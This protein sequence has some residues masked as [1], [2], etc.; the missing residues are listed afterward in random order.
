MWGL[1]RK[2]IR[3]LDR[4]RVRTLLT[5]LGIAVGV[6]GIVAIMST[7]RN[8]AEAQRSLFVENAQAHI[9]YWVWDAPASLV[10]L[11]ESDRRIVA[12][13][14]RLT[15]VTKWRTQGSW[16]DI[17]LVGIND[18]DRVRV[19]LWELLEGRLPRLD[20]VVLEASDA[21]AFG[22]AMG[23]RLTYRDFDGRER[24]ATISGTS[25]SPS[26]LSSTIT[27]LTVAYVPAPVLRRILGIS[28]S[29]QLLIRLAD[30]ADA[31]DVA[32]RVGRLLD[33]ASIQHGSAR[34]RDPDEFPGK[35][36]LDALIVIMYLFTAL[37]LVVSALL[38]TN[39]LSA[40]IAEQVRDIAI[41]KAIGATHGH[42]LLVYLVQAVLYG[43]GGTLLGL[44][45][46]SVLGWRIL[47]WIGAL[48]HVEV[49]F[50]VAAGALA[51]GALLGMGVTLLSAMVPVR[52]GSKITIH[53]ALESYG[54]A[55]TYGQ[56]RLDRAL[57]RLRALPPL[58][59]MAFRNIGR[60]RARSILTVLVIALA[61]A[62]F[63]GALATRDSVEVAIDEVYITYDA[64]A[65]VWLNR[66]V[67]TKVE[68]LFAAVDGVRIAESWTIADGVVGLADAR[69]WGLPSNSVL[70]REVMRS[71]RWFRANEPDAVVLSAELAKDQGLETG[72]LVEIQTDDVTRRYTVV[73][74]AI[75]N[76]IFLGGTLAGKAFMPRDSLG[77]M[78][79]RPHEANL[80]ALGL[81]HREAP[82][83][84]RIL[85]AVEFKLGR[86]RP[87][88][89]PVYAEIAS[90]REASRLLSLGLMAMVLIVGIIGALSIL[91]TL[92]LNVLE[93]RREIAVV[94]AIGGTDTAIVFSY[95]TEGLV[96]GALGWFVGLALG[97][98]ASRLI[99]A[100]LGDVLYAFDLVL[101]AARIGQSLAFALGLS[102]LASMAPAIAA[103]H[104]RSIDALRYE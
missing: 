84:N 42:I 73:G 2:A 67:S 46:G 27:Q 90:A 68:E 13:E 104:T 74:I 71:G 77:R 22:M 98:P 36:E 40:V 51:A 11:L 61:T 7:S 26:Y 48:G 34:I 43:I 54:I 28:G 86:W 50:T 49:A 85:E 24:H 47:V 29:N 65:W 20:Q 1:V 88:V 56:G 6:A 38:V 80:F 57:Q 89:Q 91:N 31:P 100:Q 64:D 101:S 99:V 23:D 44:L 93:R 53:N 3:D 8:I 16:A 45:G 4:R 66:S 72:D 39:T 59:A 18:F 92:T 52:R 21:R 97:Y 95:L 32:E 78:L 5:I 41:L 63:V 81:S 58:A 19:N 70:Y 79:R 96:L 15:Y 94:R 12:A 60:R 17:E 76:T 83:V 9:V 14:M 69:L 10:P 82:E 75:D 55:S 102:A 25:R 30:P 103:A 33:R 35:R 62:A 87:T 37:G